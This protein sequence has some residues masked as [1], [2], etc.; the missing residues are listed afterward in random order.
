MDEFI[1]E[2]KSVLVFIACSL[3][4][5]FFLAINIYIPLP[6]ILEKIFFYLAMLFTIGGF[7]YFFIVYVLDFVDLP[8]LEW[9]QWLTYASIFLT[10]VSIF[11]VSQGI[12]F[13][14]S[15]VIGLLQ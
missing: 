7:A 15:S 3:L 13:D 4:A 2:N 10:M 1:Q 8:E 11:V 12:G 6:L 9:W 14:G 5:S